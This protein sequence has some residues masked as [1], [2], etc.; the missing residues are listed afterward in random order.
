MI[1]FNYEDFKNKTSDE[2]RKLIE[3]KTEAKLDPDYINKFN[4]EFMDL[5][6]L[7]DEINL[8]NKFLKPFILLYYKA[9]KA[10]FKLNFSYRPLD[11][12]I[13][14]IEQLNKFV[15]HDRT[16]L[17]EIK[18]S[19]EDDSRLMASKDFI[20]FKQ[21]F[22]SGCT[23]TLIMDF[24]K[25]FGSSVSERV[26]LYFTDGVIISSCNVF[27]LPY[28]DLIGYKVANKMLDLYLER[29]VESFEYKIDKHEFS[30]YKRD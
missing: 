3:S 14:F 16:Y 6:T 10:E 8:F 19:H 27:G 28:R 5:I 11:A 2:V 1:D 23:Y 21:P 25:K 26:S 20:V 29:V 24:S 18:T 15:F 30:F 12:K 22:E 17:Q 7:Y 4:S 13:L 9:K